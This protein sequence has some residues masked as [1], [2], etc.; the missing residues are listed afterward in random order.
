MIR[1][2][3]PMG[4]VELWILSWHL[5]IPLPVGVLLLIAFLL[6]ALVIYAASLFAAAQDRRELQRLRRR[7]EELEREKAAIMQMVRVPSGPLSPMPPV[8]P[9]P[10]LSGLPGTPGTPGTPG[11]PGPRPPGSL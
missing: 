5:H 3:Y 4:D 9:M 6:G 1:S 2:I 11:S 10:G 7:V 8:V